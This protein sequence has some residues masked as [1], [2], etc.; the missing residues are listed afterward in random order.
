MAVCAPGIMEDVADDI[1]SHT[2]NLRIKPKTLSQL[3]ST[4]NYTDLI[5]LMACGYSIILQYYS[6]WPL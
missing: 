3:L 2:L 6:I 5:L 1:Q 4:V